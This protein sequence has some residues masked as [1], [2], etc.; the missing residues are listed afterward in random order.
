MRLTLVDTSPH[1]PA[2]DISP[3]DSA[4]QFGRGQRTQWAIRYESASSFPA[5]YGARLPTAQ[6]SASSSL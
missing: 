5:Q 2:L 1:E 3:L 6:A 4:L